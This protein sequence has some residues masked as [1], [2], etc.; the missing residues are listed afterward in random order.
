MA[1]DLVLVRGGGDL[2]TGVVWRLHR[3]GWPV[4]VTEL[5]VPRT[6]RRRVAVSTAVVEG[7]IEIE[8]MR[9]EFAADPARAVERARDGV[10]AVVVDPGLPDVDARVVVDAR[11]AKRN[12]DT[13]IDD[14]DLV[15]GLGPGFSPGVDCHAV[16]ETARGHHLGRVLWDR[17]PAP[18]TGVPG[19]IGGRS[20]ERVVRAPIRG[21]V[22]WRSVIGERV[23]AG[24]VLGRVGAQALVAPF[25][26]VVRGLIL[27]GIIV[28][29]GT[30]IGDVDPRGD[31]R[32]CFEISDKA[33]AIGGGV[34]EAVLTSSRSTV[35]ARR[36]GG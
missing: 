9:A 29:A 4:V 8:G 31:P 12:I 26:G 25:D 2:A 13:R 3:T 1:D 22:A 18:D 11:M 10:V 36:S 19:E 21:R 30:K 32:A 33:L 27:D 15:V 17:P 20:A 7:A 14:A 5:E 6:I 16:V 28:D 35:A 34:L 23:A 24:A